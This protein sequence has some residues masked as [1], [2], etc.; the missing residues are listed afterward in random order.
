MDGPDLQLN[1]NGTW[2]PA[3]V[4][5][6]NSPDVIEDLE[7]DGWSQ[8]WR[9][10]KPEVSPI[11]VE[12]WHRRTPNGQGRQYLLQMWDSDDASEFLQVSG[13]PAFMDLLAK[14][15]PAMQAAAIVGV[16]DEGRDHRLDRD[17]FFEKLGAHLAWGANTVLPVLEREE[18]ARREE[19]DLR[20]AEEARVRAAKRAAGTE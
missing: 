4:V 11:Y 8:F 17:G 10:G 15:A 6:S 2:E 3:E 19:S 12:T 5:P 18:K 20:E 9:I 7:K 13:F 1:A 14:W 16:I